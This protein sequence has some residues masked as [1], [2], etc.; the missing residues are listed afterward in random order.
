MNQQYQAALALAKIAKSKG[1]EQILPHSGEDNTPILIEGEI[2]G[3]Q[4]TVTMPNGEQWLYDVPAA[5]DDF[6][7]RTVLVA[8]IP[9]YP[10]A[11]SV[12]Q[13]SCEGIHP[14][15]GMATRYGVETGRAA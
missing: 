9:A 11:A 8:I 3:R 4:L 6:A 5:G 10:A 12:F 13:P 7:A 1:A 15:I 14:C 2:N